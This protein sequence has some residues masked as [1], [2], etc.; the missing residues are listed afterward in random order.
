[1][2][3]SQGRSGGEGHVDD[4]PLAV[5]NDLHHHDE[6]EGQELVH[7]NNKL[8]FHC[9]LLYHF[10]RFSL[11]F[12]YAKLIIFRYSFIPTFLIQS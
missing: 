5:D 8:V 3:V 4:E 9:Y 12:K 11:F 10:H 6:E 2:R 7:L 1:M